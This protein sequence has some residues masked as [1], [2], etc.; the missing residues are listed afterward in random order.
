VAER[1]DRAASGCEGDSFVEA[2]L[3]LT[4]PACDKRTLRRRVDGR[5]KSPRPCGRLAKKPR[6]PRRAFSLNRTAGLVRAQG[7]R[8]VE[9]EAY[10]PLDA[11]RGESGGSAA[12]VS[13]RSADPEATFEGAS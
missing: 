7:A 3:S 2:G 12:V 8:R 11:V 13:C 1:R 5:S 10:P 4:S 6:S 9:I